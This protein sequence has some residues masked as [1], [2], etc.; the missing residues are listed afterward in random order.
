MRLTGP[1]YFAKRAGSILWM[2]YRISRPSWRMTVK[3]D[4]HRQ[5]EETI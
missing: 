3:F 2:D 1:T 4:H 5:Q